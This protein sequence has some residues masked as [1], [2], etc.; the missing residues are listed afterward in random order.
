MPISIT[1]NEDI[2]TGYWHMKRLPLGGNGTFRGYNTILSRKLSVILTADD[3]HSI[4]DYFRHH[5]PG[6]F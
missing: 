6:L 5:P 1:R 3:S 4:T 2:Y